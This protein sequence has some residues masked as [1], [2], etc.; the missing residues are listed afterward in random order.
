M[1]FLQILTKHFNS[2]TYHCLDVVK[3]SPFSVHVHIVVV[4]VV[5]IIIVVVI[6]VVIVVVDV[7]IDVK[8]NIKHNKKEVHEAEN[9]EL[10]FRSGEDFL[11]LNH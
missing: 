3:Q 4:V 8:D 7:V 1:H 2:L 6:I 10:P 9:R 5:I 11:F